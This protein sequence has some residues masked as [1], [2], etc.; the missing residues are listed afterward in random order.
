ME[1]GRAGGYNP[2]NMHTPR[3]DVDRLRSRI[4]RS[5]LIETAT[6]LIEVPSPT[7]QAGAVSD[8]LA[9]MLGSEGF[10]VD[11]P[12]GGHPASPA[13][14]VRHSTGRPGPTLQFDGHLDTVHLPFVPP[15]IEDGLIPGSGASDMK[16]G[17]AAAIE[18]LRA[19]R[20]ADA[21][22]AGA[23]L[24]TAHDLHEA[25]WG[26]GRQLDQLIRE[27][28]LG[29]AVLIPEPMREPLPV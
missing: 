11:R 26:D 9:E 17:I 8:R 22:P 6:R 21:L 2:A 4:D 29:D 7:G 10:A 27:G 5:R 3:V 14:V 18:A 28:C 15:R 1:A 23:I 12:D 19:L 13:V 20:E 25:P 24:L 16:G